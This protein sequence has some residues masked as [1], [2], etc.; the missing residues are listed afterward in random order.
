MIGLSEKLRGCNANE[1][2]V[3]DLIQ[4]FKSIGG[5][6]ELLRIVVAAVQT[7]GFCEA[8]VKI[9]IAWSMTRVSSDPGAP[10]WAVIE[11]CVQVVIQ[12]GGVILK[13]IPEVTLATAPIRKPQGKSYIPTRLKWSRDRNYLR[14]E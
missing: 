12:P 5:Q 13:R 8:Q 1:I 11:Y 10:G 14:A 3:V 6:F 4:N 2:H 7:E 9:G